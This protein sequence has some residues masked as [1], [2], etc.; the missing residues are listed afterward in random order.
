MFSSHNL[1]ETQ[2]V[3][4]QVAAEEA[5]GAAGLYAGV[6]REVPGL[7]AFRAVREHL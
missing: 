5:V 7:P 6:W 2:K 3:L 1:S 4:L